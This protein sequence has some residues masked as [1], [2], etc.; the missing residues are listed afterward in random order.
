MMVLMI[1]PSTESF[2]KFMIDNR[3]YGAECQLRQESAW[4]NFRASQQHLPTLINF[5]A[6]PEPSGVAIPP[7]TIAG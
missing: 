2:S 3:V 4:G 7:G 5:A 1:N 6:C